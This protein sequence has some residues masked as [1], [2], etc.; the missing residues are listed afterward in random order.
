MRRA[1][2]SLPLASSVSSR[3]S[4]SIVIGS[5]FFTMAIAPLVSYATNCRPRG[6]GISLPSRGLDPE[7]DSIFGVLDGSL[8]G[9]AVSHAAWQLR[10]VH[11][12]GFV[13]HAPPDDHLVSV[14]FYGRTTFARSK[15]SSRAMAA[16]TL[17]RDMYSRLTASVRLK[18]RSRS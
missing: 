15:C 10:H 4:A 7:L 14:L 12:I 18:R 16:V 5:P 11:H 1:F 8:R 3:F 6:C 13:F 17:L 9:R 2:S